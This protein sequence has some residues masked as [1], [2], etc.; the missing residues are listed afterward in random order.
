D[1]GLLVLLEPKVSMWKNLLLDRWRRVHPVLA[2]RSIF[3]PSQPPERYLA[4]SALC[5]AIL[6]PIQF[7]GGNSSLECF[8]VGGPVVT[9]PGA[10]LRNRITYA[11]Y[12]QI[13]FE[14]LI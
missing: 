2:D 13:G 4:L 5:D 3:L 12:K 1:K 11:A 14:D 8:A 7:G 6:D 9:L 10:L